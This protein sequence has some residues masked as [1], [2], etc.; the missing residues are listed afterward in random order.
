MW[1]KKVVKREGIRHAFLAKKKVSIKR[2][3]LKRGLARGRRKRRVKGK[4]LPDPKPKKG[5]GV[6]LRS[7]G[8]GV[9]AKT[10]LNKE[11]ANGTEP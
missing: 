9:V 7:A 8:K 4:T 5:V 11:S 3:P 10:F 6:E 2:E 1:K